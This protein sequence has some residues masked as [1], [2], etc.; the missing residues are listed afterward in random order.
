M[1]AILPTLV[2]GFILSVPLAAAVWLALRLGQRSLNAATRYGFWWIALAACIALP[3]AF[4]PSDLSGRLP[5]ER[6]AKPVLDSRV[7]HTPSLRVGSLE[8]P[9][10]PVQNAQ[11]ADAITQPVLSVPDSPSTPTADAAT[12][13]VKA[14]ILSAAKNLSAGVVAAK[15]R[16]LSV[17]PVRLPS[18]AWPARILE[19]WALVSLLMFARLAA[20]FALLHSQKKSAADAPPA[21]RKTMERCLAV[22]ALRGRASREGALQEVVSRQVRI[23]IVKSGDSPMVAGPLRPCVLI[24]ARL[25]SAA[26]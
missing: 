24:P 21:L 19:L 26:R 17:A 10:A 6:H 11:D 18:G 15:A 23:A 22:C 8:G 4:L 16:F 1:N 2:N 5:I 3:A 9:L 25:L 20:S 13:R 14:V 7:P 12:A